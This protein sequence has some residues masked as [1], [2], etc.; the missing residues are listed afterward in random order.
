MFTLEKVSSNS[1]IPA[2]KFLGI[3]IDQSL[4]FKY[5]VNFITSKIS[6]AMYFLRTAKNLLT[7]KSLKS[8]YYASCNKQ[9]HCH[10]IYG[11]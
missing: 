7:E 6:K 5:H 3:Y 9:V 8:L 4:S 11:I 2:I 1:D 10:L